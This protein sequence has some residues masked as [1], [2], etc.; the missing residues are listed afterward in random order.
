MSEII[1]EELIVFKTSEG[2]LLLKQHELDTY[3]IGLIKAMK[4]VDP[5]AYKRRVIEKRK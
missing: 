2:N 5:E 1:N 4:K 3:M